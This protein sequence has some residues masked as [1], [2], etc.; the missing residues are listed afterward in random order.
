M[1]EK[2]AKAARKQEA[3]D[4]AWYDI[5]I[6]VKKNGG[7]QMEVP[8][9]SPIPMTL[10]VLMRCQKQVWDTFLSTLQAQQAKQ[11]LVKPVGGIPEGLL[12][13]PA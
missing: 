5:I 11:Q 1:S 3:V 12:R 9:G 10:D 2:Q 4:E 7:F 6:S 13:R 8:K